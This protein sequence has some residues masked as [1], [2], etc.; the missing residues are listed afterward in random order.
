MAGGVIRCTVA[1]NIFTL[2]KITD[3]YRISSKELLLY[4]FPVLALLQFSL[5]TPTFQALAHYE[6]LRELEQS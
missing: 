4:E 5:L 6:R 3:V 1:L 2:Q